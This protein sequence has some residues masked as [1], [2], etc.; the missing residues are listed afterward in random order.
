MQPNEEGLVK[1]RLYTYSNF[2]EKFDDSLFYQPRKTYDYTTQEMFKSLVSNEQVQ[3]MHDTDWA[4]YLAELV[5]CIWLQTFCLVIPTYDQQYRAELIKFAR[6]MF[7]NVQKR[8]E[9]MRE[10]EMMY[11]K[12]F[13]TC[14][15][16][17][18]AD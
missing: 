10:A 11:R 5:Y 2:P 7:T 16:V 18:M 15:N 14:A 17:N 6:K 3:Q 12:L 1:G 13:E 9:P 8:L 4:K